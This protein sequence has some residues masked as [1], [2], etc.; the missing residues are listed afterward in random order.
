[1]TPQEK[2]DL[3]TAKL[4]ELLRHL[5][6]VDTTNTLAN[7]GY[8]D[9]VA[10]LIMDGVEVTTLSDALDVQANALGGRGVGLWEFMAPMLLPI[11]AHDGVERE[12]RRFEGMPLTG[13][14]IDEV[15]LELGRVIDAASTHEIP[16][17]PRSGSHRSTGLWGG[18]HEEDER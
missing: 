6:R 14:V 4:G 8:W 15:L 13:R 9:E 3:A 11:A 18:R 2:K 1:M 16:K 10:R 5:V 12:L 7:T 17:P